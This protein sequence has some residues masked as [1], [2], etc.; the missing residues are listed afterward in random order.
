MIFRIIPADTFI[1]NLSELVDFLIEHQNQ[2]III[3]NGS[4]GCC[5]RTVGLYDWLDKFKFSSVVIETSNSLETHDKYKIKCIFPWKFLNVQQPIEPELHTWNKDAVFGTVYGRPLW[6][7]LGL[8]SHLLAKHNGISKVGFTIDPS[9]IDSRELYEITQLWQHHPE[10]LVEFASI[11]HQFP[12]IHNDT[13]LYSPGTTMTDGYVS[14]TKKIYPNFLIDIVAETFTSGNCF[15]ITEKTVRPML[16]KKPFI[17]MAS[18]DHLLYLRQLGFKTFGE[19]WDEDYDGYSVELR[20]KKILELI[21]TLALKSTTELE[22]MYRGMQYILDHNYN[23][24]M[25]ESF[26]K[27]ITKV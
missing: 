16:L 11:Q 5:A 19:F 2:E 3:N 25:S 21:D 6:H 18:Q 8:A 12:L 20:F 23:L 22:S 7:R 24:L 15:F 27:K 10:S 4:E 1:W 13:E 26:D 14:Q 9:K 17:A